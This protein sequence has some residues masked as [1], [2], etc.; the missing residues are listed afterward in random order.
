MFTKAAKSPLTLPYQ[1]VDFQKSY[2][3]DSQD[4]IFTL[5]KNPT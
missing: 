4:N 3:N 2:L 1:N 5:Q